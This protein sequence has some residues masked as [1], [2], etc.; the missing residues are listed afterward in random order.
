MVFENFRTQSMALDDEVTIHYRIG[1]EGPP[2]LLLHGCPQT[3]LMWHKLVPI[4]AREFTV[5]ASDLRGYGDSSKPQGL[6]DHANYAFR[7]MAADQVALMERLGFASFSAAGH[8]RGARVLH[9][10][11]LDFP[12]RLQRLAFLDILPTTVLYEQTDRHFA[13]SYWEW[14]FFTQGQGFP[15]KLLGADPESFL[16]YELGHLADD[17]TIAPEIWNDYL[18]VLQDKASMHGMCEDYR[19]GATIDLAHDATDAGRRLEAP[20]LLLWGANNPVWKR[21]DMI[22][23]WQK[24]AGSVVGRPIQAGHYLAEEA[25]DRVLAELLPFMR[26]QSCR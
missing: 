18:R 4:L 24:F 16:R 6:P 7:A 26:M 19:A 22:G 3:H 10:M 14:F 25:P 5:V 2:L 15:E 23:T 20:L 11:A 21:F 8:D 1:G 12:D 13:T 9:R 17:G